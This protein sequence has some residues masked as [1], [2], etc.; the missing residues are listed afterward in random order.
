[1]LK[2]LIVGALAALACASQAGAQ[3]FPTRPIT[4]VVPYAAGGPV[5]TIARFVGARLNEVL[6]QQIIIENIGGAGGMTGASRV[7]KATPDGYYLLFAGS[8][9]LAQNQTLYKKPLYNSATDFESVGLLTD[10]PRV[11]IT[12]KDFPANTMPE[13]IAY[14]KANQGKMQYYSAG[15][16]SGSHICALLLDQAMGTHITHVPYRGAGPAM[17]DMIAGRTDY[18]CEQISTA[19]PHIEGGNVKAIAVLGLDRVPVLANLPTAHEGGLRE[20]DCGAWSAIVAPK[21]TPAP[22][23]QRLAAAANEALD[24]SVLRERLAAVGV[25]IIPKERRGP[26][27][28]TK[29]IPAEIDKWAAPIKASGVLMD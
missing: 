28:L 13:F 8:G 6:G 9:N 4:M 11:L 1:M 21:G 12:R 18:T 26:G 17:Q 16:G 7:A 27:Y 23:V 25:T 29:Y 19:F 14:A 5:D 3:D 24:T 2:I 15:A 10:S 20:L 22:I